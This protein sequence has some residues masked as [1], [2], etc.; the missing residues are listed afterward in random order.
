MKRI[1]LEGPAVEPVLLAEAKAHLRL[2]GNA[3]DTLIAALIA[4]ARVAVEVEIRRVLI[5]QKWRAVIESWPRA[6]IVLPV[7]PLLSVGNGAGD[8][9]HRRCRAAG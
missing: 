9:Q 7:G 1:L 6:A 8:R 5:A 3:E 2:D 4:A